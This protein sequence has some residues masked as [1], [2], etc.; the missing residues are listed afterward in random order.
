MPAVPP[1]KIGNRNT[2][3]IVRPSSNFDDARSISART[4]L[5]YGR[6]GFST[7]FN[8]RVRLEMRLDL[9]DHVG[10]ISNSKVVEGLKINI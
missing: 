8:F 9:A 10:M 1:P 7:P 3:G 5:R 6:M 4:E 2:L